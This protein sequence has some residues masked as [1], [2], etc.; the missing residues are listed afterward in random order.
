MTSFFSFAL[1]TYAQDEKLVYYPEFYTYHSGDD[2][3]WANPDFNDSAWETI[4]FE[5]FPT[6][7]G[8][9]IGWFRYKVEVDTRLTTGQLGIAFYQKGAAEVYINGERLFFSGRVGRTAGFEKPD[10]NMHLHS[11]PFFGDSVLMQRRSQIFLAVK[12]SN[13]SFDSPKW[14]G[15]I[16]RF[17]FEIDELNRLNKN[18]IS[19]E[20]KLTINQIGLMSVCLAFALIFYLLFWYHS[21]I[22]VNLYF[23]LLTIFAAVNIYFELHL[24]LVKESTDLHLTKQLSQ[25]SFILF[26]LACLRFMYALTFK[27]CPRIFLIFVSFSVILCCWAWFRPFNVSKYLYV[28]MLTAIIEI[29]RSFIVSRKMEKPF[30]DRWIIGFGAV[31]L[32]A[33]SGYQVL[34]GLGI[35]PLL[36]KFYDFPTPF[37]GMLLFLISMAVFLSRN[38]ARIN[39]NLEFQLDR[40]KNLSSRALKQERSAIK[41]E[42]ELARLEA[43]NARKSK[44]LEDA[45]KLQLSMLPKNLPDLPNLEI[46]VYMQTATEVGGDYY[47]FKKHDDGT[48]TAVIGD[49]TG[50]GLQA[51]TMVAATKSVFNA[52]ANIP[53]PVNM[54]H[55]T[56]K[57]LKGMGLRGIYMAMTTAKFKNNEMLLSS[58]GMPYTLVYD[59]SKNDVK[60]IILKGMPLGS[61]IDFQYEEKCI[62]LAKGDIVLFMSDGLPEMFNEHEEMFGEER[63]MNIIKNNSDKSPKEI[64][65]KLVEAGNNWLSGKE[66]ADDVTFV[67]LKMK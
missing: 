62:S 20:N 22:K 41:K 51:G 42:V 63:A 36:W 53:E 65:A 28:F 14:D 55:K 29:L 37:Y 6:E 49:A 34:G 10:L 59:S 60:E 48:L 3:A 13:F 61:F 12:Y 15:Y 32:I 38:F 23:A 1:Q 52:L 30:K 45:R 44:E 66:Q 16:P 4:R 2:T 7:N 47:D 57:A 54:L 24:P 64:I 56:S 31:P 58:A 8:N 21:K 18:R 50:H 17:T 35:L 67:M 26:S 40:V 33:G 25:I 43:E 11:I 19:F 39:K 9:G 5:S 46:A 27:K